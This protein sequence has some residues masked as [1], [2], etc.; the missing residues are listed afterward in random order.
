MSVTFF[1]EH[2]LQIMVQMQKGNEHS[3]FYRLL[4][5]Q[6]A[7]SNL[8]WYKQNMLSDVLH[9]HF[10]YTQTTKYLNS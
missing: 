9:F 4:H 3:M 10:L 1:R 5:I 7:G 2:N 6:F 8:L